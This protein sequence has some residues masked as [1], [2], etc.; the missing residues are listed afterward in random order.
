MKAQVIVKQYFDFLAKGD[1]VAAFSL[2]ADDVQWHQP[3]NNKFSGVQHGAAQIGAMIETM[4][5]D[6]QGS[7]MV[8]PNGNLMENGN[9]VVCPVRFS[10]SKGDDLSIDMTGV[11]L[12]EIR[13][14]KIQTV[15]LFSDNQDIE[16]EFWGQ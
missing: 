10:G 13:G 3:G 12:F 8:L 2:F 14:G 4:M 7:L 9:W 16:D 6:T 11:D 1:V 15:R 5:A